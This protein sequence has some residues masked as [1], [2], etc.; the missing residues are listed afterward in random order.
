[1]R[2]RQ[3]GEGVPETPKRDQV[4]LKGEIAKILEEKRELAKQKKLE[5]P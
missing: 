1:M 5:N 3:I 4:K 2:S